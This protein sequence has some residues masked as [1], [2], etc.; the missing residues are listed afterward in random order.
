MNEVLHS[1]L[2]NVLIINTLHKVLFFLQRALLSCLIFFKK[3][4]TY[5]SIPPEMGWGEGV[6][7][8]VVNILL[9]ILS[10]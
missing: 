6:V 4:K 8:M 9:S 3:I 10:H 7:V 2:M 1:T 5:V